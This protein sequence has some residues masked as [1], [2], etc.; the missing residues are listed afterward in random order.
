MLPE[1]KIKNTPS[2]VEIDWASEQVKDMFCGCLLNIKLRR[3]G[4]CPKY[5]CEM[6]SSHDYRQYGAILAELL[7]KKP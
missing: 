6:N 1:P 4:L 7:L 3:A 5:I 2:Q